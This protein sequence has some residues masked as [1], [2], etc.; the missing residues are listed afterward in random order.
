MSK[1]VIWRLTFAGL[2]VFWIGF[3]YLVIR[4]VGAL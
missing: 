4:V 3:G 2:A 1:H